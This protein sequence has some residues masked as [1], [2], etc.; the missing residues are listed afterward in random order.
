MYPALLSQRDGPGDKV[1]G[2]FHS[3]GEKHNDNAAHLKRYRSIKS[4]YVRK[5]HLASSPGPFPAFQRCTL[6]NRRAW[7]T[8]SR[9]ACHDD[10]HGKQVSKTG[11]FTLSLP[12]TKW[13][14]SFQRP[15]RMF[16][17]KRYRLISG[18]FWVVVLQSQLISDPLVALDLL[19]T[20]LSTFVYR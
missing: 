17:C 6:K 11:H 7:Y 9:D 8:K 16:L 4:C 15:L 20:L 5:S 19:S 1:V 12:S 18:R 2:K 10:A 14:R 3:N 13:N